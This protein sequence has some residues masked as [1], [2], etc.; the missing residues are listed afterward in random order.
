VQSMAAAIAGGQAK[1]EHLP[2]S[3]NLGLP[4]PSREC[5]NCEGTVCMTFFFAAVH[6]IVTFVAGPLSIVLGWILW[7][8]VVFLHLLLC[9]WHYLHQYILLPDADQFAANSVRV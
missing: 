4:L 6:T 1:V 7:C 9:S 8:D 3:I 5:P 2:P